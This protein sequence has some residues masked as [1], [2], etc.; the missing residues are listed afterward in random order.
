MR[1]IL[2]I[3]LIIIGLTS[4]SIIFS[5]KGLLIPFDNP[6]FILTAFAVG[7]AIGL[8][9]WLISGYPLRMFLGPL[10]IVILWGFPML[11]LM[12][13]SPLPED[14]RIV[15]P[16][17]SLIIVVVLYGSYAKRRAQRTKDV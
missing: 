9:A 2:G 10:L 11:W 4:L 17:L 3:G 6:L 15:V 1:V 7:M 5:P 16:S 8:G 14:I 12:L 13:F